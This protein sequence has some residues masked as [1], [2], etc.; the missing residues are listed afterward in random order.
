MSDDALGHESDSAQ[1]EQE[2]PQ[3]DDD[4]EQQFAQALALEKSNAKLPCHRMLFNDTCSGGD[5][6]KFSHDQILL[7]AEWAKMCDKRKKLRGTLYRSDSS[8][9]QS[10]V[11]S[12]VAALSQ[13][14]RDAPGFQLQQTSEGK[15]REVKIL[16]RQESLLGIVSGLFL[17]SDKTES[18]RAAHLMADA[19]IDGFHYFQIGVALF[20]SGASADNYISSGTIEKFNLHGEV[21]LS[22]SQVKVADGRVIQIQGYIELVIRFVDPDEQVSQAKLKFR[23]LKGLSVP[24]VL[25]INAIMTHFKQLFISML[26][27]TPASCHRIDARLTEEEM[28][29][30]GNPVS[31][32]P[33]KKSESISEE[34]G[35]IPEPNSFPAANS[36]GIVPLEQLEIDFHKELSSRVSS[37]Y[38]RVPGAVDFLHSNVAV[39]VFVPNNWTGINGI[40]PVEL[41]F[42]DDFP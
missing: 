4:F 1:R 40:E 42:R 20:D 24:V 37:D 5:R 8:A 36:L 25:G 19:S 32:H 31:D 3:D 30:V 17:A 41:Q 34:E 11:S 7:D 14:R 18:W 12:S 23:V 26:S 28:S 21:Q 38:S 13:R 29:A 10:T 16:Q 33:V 35:F 15:Q 39:R 6:C 22:N 2:D 9:D 27:G